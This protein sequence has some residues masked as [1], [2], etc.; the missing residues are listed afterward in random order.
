[1][2]VGQAVGPFVID[3]VLG[4]GAMGT[5]YRARYTK[6]NARVAIKVVGAGM[7]NNPTIL[8]R[9]EREASILK[10]LDHPNI[11]KYYAHG[12]AGGSPWYAM[13]FIEGESLDHILARRDRF[14]WEEVVA[15]G[16]Q[17]CDALQHAHE[18]GIIHR[19]LKPSNLMILADDTVKLTD[20]GIAK[21]TDVTALTAA[22]ATVG[23]ASYMSPEQCKGDPNLTFKSD[24]YSL[25]IVFFELLTGRK[26][27]VAETPMEMFT[28][29]IKDEPIRPT[30]LAQECPL[31]L[32]NLII[33]LLEKEPERR[34]RDAAMVGQMLGKIR[35][36]V[37]D[38]KS[39]G[40]RA[41]SGR[42]IDQPRRPG[43]IDEGDKEAARALRGGKA[44]KK[45]KKKTGPPFYTRVWFIAP[46]VLLV[47]AFMGGL[48]Y[49]ATR[50]PSLDSIY[51]EAKPIVD[52]RDPE[53]WYQAL[54]K[55]GPLDKFLRYHY[56]A[57]GEKAKQL[58]ECVDGGNRWFY[59][60]LLD[61]MLNAQKSNKPVPKP[62]GDL[63]TLA[64]KAAAAEDKGDLAEAQ[65]LWTELK[66]NYKAE[67]PD[68]PWWLIADGRL[69]DL[70]RVP[71]EEARIKAKL[72]ND[73]KVFDGY[74]SQNELEKEVA[75]AIRLEM[76]ENKTAE[77][78]ADGIKL[79]DKLESDRSVRVWYLLALKKERDLPRSNP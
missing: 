1:M 71:A 14:S 21:D 64:L 6:N 42:A 79:K 44:R 38:R 5:V 40:E 41:A 34:P 74:V 32:D 54:N 65:K 28:A 27:F 78:G 3:K 47:L 43:K 68:R 15:L 33:H 11:V 19:D 12:R 60:R 57:E 56:S 25:G 66:T 22:H 72:L 59:G 29:H 70:E 49:L 77:A 55:D 73:L 9:F 24:L 16:E 35:Q 23:T 69:K 39:A 53:K 26:P 46:A 37:M 36:D 13:E 20:F 7:T 4:S 48:L 8:R 61:R 51:A 52:S 17:L 58:R 31:P 2:Q 10:Q 75:E 76:V 63:Q 62:D 50:P 30:R 45:P 67:G 18:K